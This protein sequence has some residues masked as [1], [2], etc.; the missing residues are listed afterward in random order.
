MFKSFDGKPQKGEFFNPYKLGSKPN[1]RIENK[2]KI[3]NNQGL[4]NID[5]NPDARIEDEDNI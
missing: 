4:N 1:Q 3:E 2:P 5:T